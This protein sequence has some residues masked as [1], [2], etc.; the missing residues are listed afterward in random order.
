[1][2]DINE[3]TTGVANC[4]NN[5]RCVNTSPGYRCDCVSGYKKTNDVCTGKIIIIIVI[6]YTLLLSLV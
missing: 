6:Y 2:I 3:C 5:S 4:S 1:M